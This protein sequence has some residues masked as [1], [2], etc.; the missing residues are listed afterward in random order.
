MD[1]GHITLRALP[2]IAYIFFIKICQNTP[3][4]CWGVLHSHRL[5]LGF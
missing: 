1:I 3:Q 4:L 2:S 5:D